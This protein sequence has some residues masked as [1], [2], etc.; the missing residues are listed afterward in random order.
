MAQPNLSKFEV[1]KSWEDRRA[2]NVPIANPIPTSSDTEFM[3]FLFDH[4]QII[5]PGNH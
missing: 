2:N 3:R 4:A 1:R 5:A